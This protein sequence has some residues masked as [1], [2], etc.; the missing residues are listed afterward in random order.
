MSLVEI[1][2]KSRPSSCRYQLTSGEREPC[3]PYSVRARVSGSTRTTQPGG[4]S[5]GRV[6]VGRVVVGEVEV[7]PLVAAALG[8]VPQVRVVARADELGLVEE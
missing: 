2:A 7:E 5:R 1:A 8:L 3:E 4:S 6:A